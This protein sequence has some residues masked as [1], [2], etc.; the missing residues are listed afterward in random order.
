MKRSAT[1]IA[2][3]LM[4]G[5]VSA[6]PLVAATATLRVGGLFFLTLTA[7]AGLH[8]VTGLTKVVSLCHVAFVGVGAYGAA[9]ASLRWGFEPAAAIL[10]GAVSAGGC[11]LLLAILTMR[12]EEHYLALGTLAAGEILLNIFRGATSLTGGANGL[13]GVPPLRFFGVVLDAPPQYYPLCLL[14][15]LGAL[16]FAWRL[17]RSSLGRSLRAMGDEGVIVESIGVSGARLRAAGFT[18]GGALAGL[19]GAVGAH[20]DGFVGPES[21]GVGLSIAYLCF[22]VIGGLGKLQGVIIGAALA[23]LGPEFFRSTLEWQM[24]AVAAVALGVLVL[25]SVRV[26]GRASDFAWLSGHQVAGGPP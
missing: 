17:E 22:L 7:L 23:S 10:T 20:I 3:G 19:A 1:L 9:I 4:I 24:V 11:S 26:G 12:L 16:L 25:R 2:A 13:A 6:L 14:V 15:A 18:I 8:V 5:A 21:F